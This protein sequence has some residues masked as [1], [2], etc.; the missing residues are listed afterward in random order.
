MTQFKILSSFTNQINEENEST[1]DNFIKNE[2][3]SHETISVFSEGLRELIAETTK[4]LKFK[5]YEKKDVLS[6]ISFK[7]DFYYLCF[8]IQLHITLPSQKNEK[9]GE[10]S[11]FV[12]M[13][14]YLNLKDEFN[15]KED[16]SWSKSNTIIEHYVS[17]EVDDN[18]KFKKYIRN[19]K[20]GPLEELKKIK[21][22]LFELSSKIDL[23]DL[24]FII[25][26]TDVLTN[27]THSGGKIKYLTPFL[28]NLR[29]ETK[30][31]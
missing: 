31:D 24:K 14:F 9:T 10:L 4:G 5:G 12:L 6:G 29:I 16:S 18:F 23:N 8:I 28:G 26:G 22:Y 15:A 25:N 13:Y 19:I 1:F 3:D 11:K 20:E 21:S 2:I 30:D 27:T 7:I 17:G